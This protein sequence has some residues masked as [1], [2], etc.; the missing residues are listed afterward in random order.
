[1]TSNEQSAS[2]TTSSGASPNDESGSEQQRQSQKRNSVFD[3]LYHDARRV[4]SFLAQFEGYGALTNVKSMEA[5]ARATTT[6]GQIEAGG[7]VPLIAQGK[8]VIDR[9]N[10]SE[11]RDSAERTFDPLWANAIRFMDFAEER[12]LIKRDIETARIG[13]IVLIKGDLALFDFSVI[14]KAWDL[15]AIR[16]MIKSQAQNGQQHGGNRAD[17]RRQGH[18]RADETPTEAELS[19]DMMTIVPHLVQA[20]VKSANASTWSSLRDEWMTI[21]PADLLLKHGTAVP[22]EWGLLGV[23]DAFPDPV[24]DGDDSR[25][26]ASLVAGASLNELGLQFAGTLAPIIRKL[27]GRPDL[28]YGVTPLIIFRE[29]SG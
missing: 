4:A 25:L 15:E 24:G 14:R 12:G 17:R 9:S 19:I 29:V 22:G 8:A 23:L 2:L 21:P 5:V 10:L 6:K 27:L 3:F 7:G 16:R 28:A 13:Q 18:L 11:E 1:M 20:S 26:F